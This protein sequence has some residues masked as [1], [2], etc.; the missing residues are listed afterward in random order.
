MRQRSYSLDAKGVGDE[1]A[2]VLVDVVLLVLL[3]RRAAAG[4]GLRGRD[5]CPSR[6]FG[7]PGTKP[8]AGR[9][10]RSARPALGNHSVRPLFAFVYSRHVEIW[11][12]RLQKQLL[13]FSVKCPSFHPLSPKIGLNALTK[14][15]FHSSNECRAIQPRNLVE[16]LA[17]GFRRNDMNICCLRLY[18]VGSQTR[19][20]MVSVNFG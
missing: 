2:H 5:Q 4:G 8:N 13:C 9:R 14:K 12:N 6:R 1:G 3:A 10:Q 7:L 20:E 17:S 18:Q 15:V 19:V 11:T 16:K